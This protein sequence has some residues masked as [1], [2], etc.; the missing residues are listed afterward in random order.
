MLALL[1]TLALAVDILP[2][3]G[4]G[5]LAHT[6]RDAYV[7]GTRFRIVVEAESREHAETA[8]EAALAEVERFDRLLS[9]WD[10]TSALS[11]VNTAPPDVPAP[12][13]HPLLELLAEAQRWA[14]ATDGAFEPTVGAM[15]DAWDLRGAGR[16]PTPA[17][18]RAAIEASRPSTYWVDTAAGT[19][20]RHDAAARL[21]AGGFGKG[22]ALRSAL[23]LLEAQR[24]SR[25][26][27]DLG[28]QVVALAGPGDAPWNVEV[29]HPQHR[30]RGVAT[31]RL[32]GVSAA[33]SGT[34]ERWVEVDGK[35]LG[36]I[37]DPRTGRPA[38]AWGSVTVVSFDPFVADVLSTALYVLGPDD[39]MAWVRDR[40]DVGVLF[41]DVRGGKFLPTW[42]PAMERWLDA[43]SFHDTTTER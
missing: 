10:S 3:G 28:G 26:F 17:E 25:A 42:N 15:V 5:A 31:L 7:M 12:A 38:P 1:C 6:E 8:A 16:R 41:L 39:G 24:I 11:R 37:L 29:A 27:L 43:D 4:P 14:Q 9:T 18:L 33:T 23:R 19:V 30:E 40:S 34:S 32:A 13:P 21:D 35:R 22:A 36:H 2:L 20:T